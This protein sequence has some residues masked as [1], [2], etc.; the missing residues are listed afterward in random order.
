MELAVTVVDR[1][2]E[3][4]VVA[5]VKGIVVRDLKGNLREIAVENRRHE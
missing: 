4:A 1:R 3:A 5:V 2:V